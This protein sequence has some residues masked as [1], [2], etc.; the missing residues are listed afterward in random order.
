MLVLH[1]QEFAPTAPIL[2]S[3]G[4]SEGE[5]V[6]KGVEKHP[7]PLRSELS[8]GNAGEV[9]GLERERLTRLL[10]RPNIHKM[11]AVSTAVRRALC[12]GAI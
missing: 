11:A 5:V 1:H 6:T 9:W 8:V 7:N 3:G 4:F 12:A 10:C 2:C